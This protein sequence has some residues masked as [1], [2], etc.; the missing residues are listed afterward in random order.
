MSD[1]AVRAALKSLREDRARLEPVIEEVEATAKTEQEA[2]EILLR[3]GIDEETAAIFAGMHG[4]ELAKQKASPHL[5]A[6]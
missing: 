1:P 6:A 4:E 2:L 5:E 3:H